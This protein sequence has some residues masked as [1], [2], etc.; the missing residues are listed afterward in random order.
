MIQKPDDHL[1][2]MK[3][4]VHLAMKRMDVPRIILIAP[5]TFD[6][7]ALS[8]VLQEE[9]GIRPLAL[10][11]LEKDKVCHCVE[12]E[13]VA[14]AMRRILE[15]GMLHECGWLLIDLPR[16]RKEA[17]VF[18][19]Y[20]ILPTHAIQLITSN[21]TDNW[22]WEHGCKDACCSKACNSINLPKKL[23]DA[24]YSRK[25]RELRE[26]Y[27]N[28]LIEVEVGIRT[29]DELGRDIAKLAKTRKHSRAPMASPSVFRIALIGSRG[30]GCNALAKSLAERFNL[31]HIDYDYVAEQ[32][33]LQQNPLGEKLRA[34][35]Y[36]WGGRPK[37]EIRI[38]I[39]QKHILG[40]ECSRN[41][42]VLTGYPK[43]VDDFK[44]LDLSAAP[45]NRVIFLEVNGDVCRERLLNRRYNI[46]TGSEHTLSTKNYL[47][48]DNCKLA[49]HPNDYRLIVERDK[50]PR[51]TRPFIR[52]PKTRSTLEAVRAPGWKAPR[53]LCHRRRQQQRQQQQQ[54]QQL[55]ENPVARPTVLLAVENPGEDERRSHMLSL[56]TWSV[57]FVARSI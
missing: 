24:R 16:S 50:I 44:L 52:T 46:V 48:T 23:E 31:D 14:L 22:E 19:R 34:F 5:P 9:L 1:V 35:E 41:G 29:V 51:T 38:E 45:P 33:R 54:Q 32:A 18:Q 55:L 20:G 4:Y 37:P 11:D 12:S 15:N 30:S 42:W 25:L 47:D 17:R 40:Y 56:L 36:R 7:V 21:D 43:S 2:F 27:A 10:K 28:C 53:Q 49:V 6:R 57:N 39:V 13:D 26:A 8:R 3:Q